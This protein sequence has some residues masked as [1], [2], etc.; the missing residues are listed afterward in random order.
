MRYQKHH[1]RYIQLHVYRS[2]RR[3]AGSQTS[4]RCGTIEKR[5]WASTGFIKNAEDADR[6]VRRGIL[7]VK[8]DGEIHPSVL[9]W[10]TQL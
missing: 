8:H 9:C 2:H 5:L 4:S 7:A 10:Y 1:S 6:K 3:N